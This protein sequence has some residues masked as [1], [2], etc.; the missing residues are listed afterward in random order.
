MDPIRSIQELQLR[1]SNLESQ[2]QRNTEENNEIIRIYSELAGLF[3]FMGWHDDARTM[4]QLRHEL[5]MAMMQE[6]DD[7]DEYETGEMEDDQGLPQSQEDDE[8]LL[9]AG[10]ASQEYGMLPSSNL[11]Q[12]EP[13]QNPPVPM[14]SAWLDLFGKPRQKKSS[15]RPKCEHGRR[16]NTCTIC[17][18][19]YVGPKRNRG[20]QPN[21]KLTPEGL[22]KFQ[23]SR[24]KTAM[25]YHQRQLSDA[26]LL[27][28]HG[29]E[30]EARYRIERLLLVKQQ[31]EQQQQEQQQQEQQQQEQSNGA[32]AEGGA[33]R[34]ITK[35]RHLTK[36]KRLTKRKK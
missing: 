4:N 12:G 20:R 21:I 6:Y 23:D 5:E 2:Q 13:G 7:D 3:E 10:M 29:M 25:A 28:H 26:L 17:K 15:F 9:L 36:R 18:N 14:S 16:Q 35:R 11:G 30:K 22:K 27:K 34:L 1:L 32:I 31:Q 8:T 33:K 19:K 24:F